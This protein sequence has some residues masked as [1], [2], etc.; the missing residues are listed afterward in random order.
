[1]SR[2]PLEWHDG[3]PYS[4]QYGDVYF[5]RDSGL[6]ETRHV[7]LQHN[8]LAERWSHLPSGAHFVIGETGFG[9]GLNLLAAWQLWRQVAPTDAHLH[10]V[11]GEAW[12]LSLAELQQ[13]H[14]AWPE[15]AE[16]AATLH[17]VW[18][19]L[20]PG[21]HRLH[22]D[23]HVSLTLLIGDINQTLPELEA[24]VDAWFLD[25]FSPARNPEMWNPAL[26]AQLA[27]LAAPA[28]TLAT[29]TSA[30]H[31]RRGLQEAGFEVAR[32]PGHG[33]KREMLAG[34]R[35]Q[36]GSQHAL[37][38]YRPVSGTP[39]EAIVLGGG[40]AGCAAAWSLARRGWRVTLLEQHPGL[41]QE[42]SG[43]AAGVLYARL[44]PKMGPLA[45]LILAGLQY[46]QRIMAP[47]LG[48]DG[49]RASRCGVLQLAFD[50]DEAE[51]IQQ[52][53][54]LDLPTS[55]LQPVDAA[56]ASTLAGVS[57]SQ[58]GLFFPQAGWVHPP[59]LCQALTTHP[60]ISVH[61]SQSITQLQQHEQG[62]Q[63]HS[64]SGEQ[65]Q[66]PVLVL[67]NAHHARQW[68]PC[69]PIRTLKGQVSYLPATVASQ[70]LRT[71]VCAEG[72]VAPARQGLHALGATFEPHASDTA[73][74]HAG[75]LDNLHTLRQLHPGLHAA[76]DGPGW[77]ARLAGGQNLAGLGGRAAFRAVCPDYS[78][79]I[80]P[81]ADLDAVITPRRLGQ[82][83]LQPGEA[84]LPAL[85]GLFA[86][87]AH[88]TRGLITAPLAGEVLAAYLNHEPSPLPRAQ[89]LTVHPARFPI[90]PQPIRKK[91]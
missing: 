67:A 23:A 78:P 24:Q 58:G 36:P 81:L 85:P 38:H 82:P 83:L 18:H 87:L 35:L 2:P 21:F 45:Q 33:R 80:G 8:Q 9:T 27:R 72:Y 7:F 70:S 26:Y 63:V 37:Q 77:Q 1:M 41:A 90:P 30:G 66:A 34:Q 52:L 43:N 88:G 14:A 40:M 22:L 55:L 39:R 57:M 42:A 79:L 13:A 6:D 19:D 61:C 75:H 15:L 56:T 16:L 5:S 46:S 54:A 76:L 44:A 31:V 29:F 48:W 69:L 74:T 32:A 73:V 60:L 10:F 65:W 4:S 51:R 28:C 84:A 47:L 89:R 62:W 91:G 20:A 50:V 59:A 53:A 25:G 71:V 11:S 12:P 64:A 68:Q 3:Q 49:E 17:A 86:T